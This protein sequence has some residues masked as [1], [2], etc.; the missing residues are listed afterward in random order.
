L[1][2]PFGEAFDI[3]VAS[4]SFQRKFNAI[5]DIDESD[6]HGSE[7]LHS[8]SQAC[9]CKYPSTTMGFSIAELP[10]QHLAGSGWPSPIASPFP[11]IIA[12]VGLP[13]KNE[14]MEVYIRFT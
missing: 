3:G 10:I 8:G 9:W 13:M 12:V 7:K 6:S 14:I 2:S 1:P 5:L 11:D 4:G